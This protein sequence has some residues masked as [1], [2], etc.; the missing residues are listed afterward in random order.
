[1]QPC[2]SS[3]PGRNLSPVPGFCKNNGQGI[4][5]W[6]LSS[7]GQS[8]NRSNGGQSFDRDL[9]FGDGGGKQPD[10]S[11]QTPTP[12]RGKVAQTPALLLGPSSLSTSLCQSSVAETCARSAL[13]PLAGWHVCAP[14]DVLGQASQHTSLGR[15]DAAYRAG[16]WR[17]TLCRS[18]CVD[19]GRRRTN[20]NACVCWSVMLECLL[21]ISVLSVLCGT[22][23]ASVAVRR[24]LHGLRARSGG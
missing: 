14:G 24:S 16:A 11:A 2:Q 8:S 4:T 9:P 19:V 22:E 20:R 13:A 17:R 3:P 1:M 15:L 6:V 7:G 23:T 21:Q 18:S 10:T 5:P 12:V